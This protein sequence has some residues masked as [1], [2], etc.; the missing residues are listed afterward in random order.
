M[1]SGQFPRPTWATNHSSVPTPSRFRPQLPCGYFINLPRD[2]WVLRTKDNFHQLILW[3]ERQPSNGTV[4]RVDKPDDQT[5]FAV[6]YGS[7]PDNDKGLHV[8][9][10]SH[11]SLLHFFKLTFVVGDHLQQAWRREV[12]T[13]WSRL[14]WQALDQMS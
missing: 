9:L 8:M 12:A 11:L 10:V 6:A 13:R 7:V 4:R 14:N 3:G 2:I 5:R 1:A